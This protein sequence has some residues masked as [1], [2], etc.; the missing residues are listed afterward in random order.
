VVL[1]KCRAE[2]FVDILH[3][4]SI[5]GVL[6]IGQFFVILPGGIDLGVAS[7]LDQPATEHTAPRTSAPSGKQS[8]TSGRFRGITFVKATFAADFHK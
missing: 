7:M 1:T 4:S 3:Q 5:I 8:R 6:A 2:N